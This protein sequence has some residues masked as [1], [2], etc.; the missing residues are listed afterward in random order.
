MSRKWVWGLAGLLALIAGIGFGAAHYRS[1]DQPTADALATLTS[2]PFGDLEGGKHP[3]SKWRGKV[4]VV[5]F[6][7]T[8]CAPCLYEI[9][10]L[11]R[12]QSRLGPAGLQIVGIALDS[13]ENARSYAGQ[14]KMNYPVYLAGMETID[15]A[16]A[17]GNR[18][19]VLPYTVI[20][21][22]EGRLLTTHLGILTE[23]D[24][25]RVMARAP[26]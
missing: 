26:G 12:A 22:R 5:N 11:M 13:P 19:G 23:E 24:L 14:V 20:L 16:R 15:L 8:W 18:S 3:L 25:D 21:D 7:A 17:L 6:W 9:P 2:R 10:N 4:L 1:R